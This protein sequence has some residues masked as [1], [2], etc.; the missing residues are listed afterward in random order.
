MTFSALKID[1]DSPVP[2]YHQL[3]EA[4]KEQI[5]NGDLKPNEKIPSENML[6]ETYSISKMTVRQAMSRLVSEGLINREQ[7]RGTFVAPKHLKHPLRRM[8][9]FTED[10]RS[11]NLEPGSKILKFERIPAPK[12]VA[13]ALS[14]EHGEEVT[15][16]K[17]L[18]LAND[19]TVGLH[20][21]YLRKDIQISQE[22]LESTGSLYKL[23][24]SKKGVQFKGGEDSIEAIQATEQLS[25]ILKVPANTALLQVTRIAKDSR[26]EPLE[27][28]V[29]VYR[30]DLYR[31]TIQ[32]NR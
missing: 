17:R 31:Y 24:E 12:E 23:L 19:R 8:A 16:I 29:A 1:K 18:R 10:M 25:E 4:I 27:Y 5:L 28:V 6:A 15:R 30:A 3:K 32:L 26:G 13:E 7:G 20:D 22:S 2:M 11:R 14:I 21:T 9:S